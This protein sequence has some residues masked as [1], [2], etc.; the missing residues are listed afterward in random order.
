MLDAQL[1][2]LT[3]N[4]KM[5]NK[6]WV[7]FG[8]PTVRFYIETTSHLGYGVQFVFSLGITFAI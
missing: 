2:V 6:L 3:F 1:D 4:D 5:R 7:D 8:V